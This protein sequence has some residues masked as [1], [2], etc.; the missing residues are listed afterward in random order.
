VGGPTRQGV[1]DALP[2]L[3]DVPS[4]KYGKVTFDL[5]SRRVLNPR[6]SPLVVKENKFVSWDGTKPVAG[7]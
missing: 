1:H 4:V 7:Q 2:K 6:F 3:K 5:E